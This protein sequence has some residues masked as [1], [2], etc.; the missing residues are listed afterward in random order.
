MLYRLARIASYSQATCIEESNGQALIQIGRERKRFS[1]S[2]V[3]TRSY[4][5]GDIVRVDGQLALI[6]MREPPNHFILLV[7][8]LKREVTLV[9]EKFFPFTPQEKGDSIV[10]D[11]DDGN[12][13]LWN[14]SPITK[15]ERRRRAF[16]LK[17]KHGIHVIHAYD[18]VDGKMTVAKALLLKCRN[19]KRQG[20]MELKEM[21]VSETIIKAYLANEITIEEAKEIHQKNEEDSKIKLSPDDIFIKGKR[22][23]GSFGFSTK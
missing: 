11:K 20:E 9:N 7:G 4:T 1:L 18:V 17:N 16:Y 5:A 14:I 6:I 22:L 10:D 3:Q 15:E 8:K 23:G 19:E 2:D 21:G 12:K 13:I